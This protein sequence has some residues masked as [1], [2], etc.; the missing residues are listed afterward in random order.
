MNGYWII[1]YYFNIN[2]II[3]LKIVIKIFYKYKKK[4]YQTKNTLSN[5]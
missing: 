4:E 5:L 2:F 3:K 1:L